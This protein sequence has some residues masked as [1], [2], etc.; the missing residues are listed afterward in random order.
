M[1]NIISQ[2]L[3]Y[4]K[5]NIKVISMNK[6][7]RCAVHGYIKLNKIEQNMIDSQL[8]QRLRFIH[9]QGTSFYTSPGATHSRSEHS[10]RVMHLSDR[11]FTE[12]FM[13][14]PHYFDNRYDLIAQL[15]RLIGLFHDVGHG[16]FSHVSD[17]IQYLMLNKN[18]KEEIDTLDGI[19]SPHE[20]ITYLIMK[21]YLPRYLEKI[22]DVSPKL[23]EFL[24]ENLYRV[25]SGE[26]VNI[27]IDDKIEYKRYGLCINNIID[28]EIDADKMDFLMRDSYLIGLGAGTIDIDRLM[29][30]ADIN[31]ENDKVIYNRQAIS[32][33]EDLIIKRYQEYKWIN[34]H[35][36]VC[37]TDEMMSRLI[38]F[39]VKNGIF[40][41]KLFKI[42]HFKEICEYDIEYF[43]RNT[44]EIM[45]EILD[46][47]IILAKLRSMENKKE[48]EDIKYYVDMM[49]RRKLYKPLWKVNSSFTEEEINVLKKLFYRL[50]E[51][52]TDKHDYDSSFKKHLEDVIKDKLGLDDIIL[53]Y[54]PYKPIKIE[55]DSIFIKTE[56][57][58]TP[59]EQISFIIQRLMSK[60]YFVSPPL[61]VPSYIFVPEKYSSQISNLKK[62][63]LDL[64]DNEIDY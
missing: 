15:T 48:N 3:S 44:K 40:N 14:N 16:P 56:Q 29:R 64:I 21:D 52:Y 39:G 37:F 59:I 13:K 46:D 58:I 11:L 47:R 36:S 24:S 51:D 28:S 31:E 6:F 43:N 27:S 32:S 26:P 7:V 25:Y 20:Y 49:E 60:D 34:F 22:N 10:L 8:F 17:S 4:Y 62:D 61:Y 9:Q 50:S 2:F 55:T 38:Y 23:S 30:T 63:I 19:K 5:S 33:V 54:K 41:K 45:S 35:H 1:R 42:E 57:G 53:T 12:L 18:Q